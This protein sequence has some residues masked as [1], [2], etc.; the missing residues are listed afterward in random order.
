ME[1]GVW[2]DSI[3]Y[4]MCD[5]EALGWVGRLRKSL[6]HDDSTRVYNFGI[7]GDTT[8]NLLKRFSVEV[9]AIEPNTIIFAIGIND[10]KFPAGQETNW[11]PLDVFKKNIKELL[12]QA[13][14]YTD[15][16]HFVGATKVNDSLARLSGTRFLNETIQS[17]NAALKEIAEAEN[18][19]FIDVFEILNPTVDLA[20]GL[21][22]N[23][24]GY[25]KMYK[26]I[27]LHI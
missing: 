5:S 16:I 12:Q 10:S 18:L 20:D 26:E 23:A 9:D 13:R 15:I 2:G 11:V 3:A 17:Y 4:G 6:A 21:H 25:E 22:P 8:E 7:C 27:L 1:I 14:K 24:Q 19:P